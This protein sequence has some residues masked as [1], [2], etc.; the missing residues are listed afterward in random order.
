MSARPGVL[1]TL[2][3]ALVVAALAAACGWSEDP[4]AGGGSP[5][6]TGSTG[7]AS[8]S[9]SAAAVGG[10][11]VRVRALDGVL[12]A[13]RLF[14]SGPVAVVLAHQSDQTQSGWFFFAEELAA[15]GY[16]ALT[17][18]F[19]GYCSPDEGGCSGAGSAGADGWM[20]VG[21]AV[22]FLRDRGAER[23]YL[24]GAS[25]GGAAVLR[26]AA[27]GVPIDGVASLSGVPIAPYELDAQA[28]S[29]IEAPLLFVVGRFDGDLASDVRAVYGDA[30]EPKRLELLATGEHGTGLLRSAAEAHQ[31]RVREALLSLYGPP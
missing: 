15:S 1:R 30:S 6:P 23:V 4:P 7:A 16:T 26:A 17:F 22:D 29:R 5:S 2:G 10:E 31:A 19:R 18:T 24:T 11:P 28:L 12:I 13:G 27:E 8:A 20:D 21:G 9:P 14:G 25:L 3:A